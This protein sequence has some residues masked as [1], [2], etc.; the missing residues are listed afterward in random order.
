MATWQRVVLV[1]G[2]LVAGVVAASFASLAMAGFFYVLSSEEERD[3]STQ[4]LEVVVEEAKRTCMLNVDRVAPGRHDVLVI[5]V[6]ADS[7]VLIRDRS[8]RVV[9]RQAV[10]AGDTLV[11][12]VRAVALRLGTYD[13]ECR[14]GSATMN[15]ELPVVPARELD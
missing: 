12:E 10:E 6:D 13:V 2:L 1:A 7:R 14:T 3:W 11:E 5:A 4:P 9:F 15:V 8:D